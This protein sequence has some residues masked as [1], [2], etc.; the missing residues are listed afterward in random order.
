MFH[1]E[2]RPT[3]PGP[4]A[5]F[6]CKGQAWPAVSRISFIL[7][8][9]TG[10]L[11]ERSLAIKCREPSWDSQGGLIEASSVSRRHRPGPGES[12][13]LWSSVL[14]LSSFGA[15]SSPVSCTRSGAVRRVGKKP[16][17]T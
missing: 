17:L 7:R 12:G 2:F 4:P 16:N 11:K 1:K 6:F 3:G 10:W 5:G 8:P 9:G 15:N 13:A 14:R